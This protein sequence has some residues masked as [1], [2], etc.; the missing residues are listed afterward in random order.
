[1]PGGALYILSCD[2][3]SDVVKFPQSVHFALQFTQSVIKSVAELDR[4]VCL[5]STLKDHLPKQE[6]CFQKTLASLLFVCSALFN[7]IQSTKFVSS[8]APMLYS[9]LQYFMLEVVIKRTIIS[10]FLIIECEA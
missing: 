1:M 2:W 3:L 7:C 6:D 4:T 5:Y 9:C 8:S 10:F